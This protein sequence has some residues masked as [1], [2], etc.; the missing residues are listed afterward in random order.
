MKKFSLYY[1]LIIAVLTLP[2][3]CNKNYGSA[4]GDSTEVKMADPATK[5]AAMVEVL[6]IKEPLS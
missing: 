4:E 1:L 3:S 6:P 5:S 2:F